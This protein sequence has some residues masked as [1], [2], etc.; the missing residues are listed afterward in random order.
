[1]EGKGTG[2]ASRMKVLILTYGSRG[3][4][5]PHVALGRGLKERGHDVLIA[6]AGRFRDFVEGNGLRFGAMTDDLLAIMDTPQGRDLFE[7]GGNPA[8]VLR[9]GLAMLRRVGPLQRELL[10]QSWDIARDFAPDLIVYHPKA[11]AAPHIAEKLG[12]ACVLTALAP[13]FQ[14]TR[15]FRFFVAPD[16]DLGGWLNRATFRLTLF[17]T[18]RMWARFIP[19]FRKSLG[20]PATKSFDMLETPDGRPIPILHA[21]SEAVVPR[22]DDW[23]DTAHVTGYWFLDAQDEWSP[24]KH[25]T[26]FLD[27]GPPPVYV[28]FGSMA[29]GDPEKLAAIVVEALGRAGLRGI[30]ASGWGGLRTGDLPDTILAIDHAPH[31]WLFPR[32]ATVV[33]HGGA[34]ST[35]AG[36]RAGKPSVIVP[37][38]GDQPFWGAR[39]HRLGAGPKPIPRGKLTVER[40]E[41][42]LRE[43]TGSP[44]VAEAAARIGDRIRAE[45]GV[46]CAVKLIEA[47]AM[48]L[49]RRERPD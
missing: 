43:A 29:G 11:G 8:G 15:A 28:G 5:Q 21:H 33:H 30:V 47:M 24:P 3:D 17:A 19:D 16:R 9:D 39:V 46:G 44:A 13:M 22:P 7:K 23:P 45:D 4:V 12:I 32:M 37:F 14:P 27:A 36:L 48:Q 26:E 40:L 18:A 41:K 10:D 1:M 25:L 6:T 38:F 49:D 42:A 34:G 31:G 20:L 2:Y 35:A